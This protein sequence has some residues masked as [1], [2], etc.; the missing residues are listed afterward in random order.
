[1]D[2]P[3]ADNVKQGR[4]DSANKAPNVRNDA[5]ISF[6]AGSTKSGGVFSGKLRIP[7]HFG[8]Y[9]IVKELGQGGMGAV[10]LAFDTVLERQVA[11]KIPLFSAGQDDTVVERFMQEARSAASIRHASICPIYDVGQI[12]G[13]RFIS[14]AY[15]DG[16]PLGSFIKRAKTQ[17]EKSVALAI[18]KLAIGLDVAHKSGVVHR[19]LKPN[20]IMV[21]GNGD[22]IVMDFGLARR[23]LLGTS[24]PQLTQSGTLLGT[25]AYMSPEQVL[26]DSKSVGPE[27]DIYSLGVVMYELLTGVLPFQGTIGELLVRIA[28]EAPVPPTQLRP[29]LNPKLSSICEKALAKR[30]EDRFPSMAEFASALTS[31]LNELSKAKSIEAP[32]SESVESATIAFAPQLVEGVFGPQSLPK[33]ADRGVHGMGRMRRLALLGGSLIAVA[34]AAFLVI[35]FSGQSQQTTS[36]NRS[37]SHQDGAAAPAPDNKTVPPITESSATDQKADLRAVPEGDVDSAPSSTAD[38]EVVRPEPATETAT[39][40]SSDDPGSSDVKLAAVVPRAVDAVADK[41]IP[42]NVIP[43]TVAPPEA[44]ANTPEKQAEVPERL[45]D[46]RDRQEKEK[47][48]VPDIGVQRKDKALV[49]KVFAEKMAD[50]DAPALKSSLASAMLAEATKANVE[51]TS[52]YALARA[53]QDLALKAEDLDGVLAAISYLAER[54]ELDEYAEKANAIKT[55]ASTTKDDAAA[56]K[57]SSTALD[58]CRKAIADHQLESADALAATV[59]QLQRRSPDLDLRNAANSLRKRIKVLQNLESTYEKA[60]DDIKR[61]ANDADANLLVGKVLCFS[62]GEWEAGLEALAKGSDSQLSELAKTDLAAQTSTD[63]KDTEQAIRVGDGWWSLGDKAPAGFY[64]ECYL[65][66]ARYWYQLAQPTT[67]RVHATHLQNRLDSITAMLLPSLQVGKATTGRAGI[68]STRRIFAAANGH[69]S[70]S[71][72]FSTSMP[73]DA[74]AGVCKVMRNVGY[75][76]TCIRP[77][78]EGQQQLVASIWMFGA[79]N[80]KIRSGNSVEMKSDAES[81]FRAGFVPVDASGTID[82]IFVVW[83]QQEKN[84]QSEFGLVLDEN[85]EWTRDGYGQM[86]SH[87]YR[88]IDGKT[89]HRV[90]WRKPPGYG[91]LW[92]GNRSL[93]ESQLTAQQGK[94][95]QLNSVSILPP[96][97]GG[98]EISYLTLWHKTAGQTAFTFGL[99]VDQHSAQCNSFMSDGFRPISID[100]KF[101]SAGNIIAASVWEK[102]PNGR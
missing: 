100:A 90:V 49:Q 47:M 93:I 69:M 51:D 85:D 60:L 53:A 13:I 2:D 63:E 97:D 1:M 24:H 10:Y 54:Y 14:M 4:N 92:D 39:N 16:K 50:A 42:Q 38:N 34:A 78:G 89:I 3:S 59:L 71:F 55:A 95:N 17:P 23:N 64:R 102:P 61:D 52:G 26:G 7:E 11:L 62:R 79:K 30:A 31:Y 86:S 41:S 98:G 33:A 12:D 101:D 72:A 66:R 22:L 45:S 75:Y 46:A 19:D 82:S 25:P 70:D 20:N 40:G 74:F 67:N 15:I 83:W 57:M 81:M 65:E 58:V 18:R 96:T 32:K 21:T 68:A 99:P 5:T 56:R 44:I 37:M 29:G 80:W 91:L 8:R 87:R 27:S 76:P 36:V 28:T 6:D 48:P 84:D 73:I 35:T 88:G 43:A 94:E 77:Y 9:H